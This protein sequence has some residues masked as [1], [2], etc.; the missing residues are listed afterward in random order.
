[1]TENTCSG[2]RFEAN[3]K[4][5]FY[6]PTVHTVEEWV[7][8]GHPMLGDYLMKKQVSVFPVAIRRCGQFQEVTK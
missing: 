8:S 7:D 2:C 3:G 6:P 5:H 1:M 4:C